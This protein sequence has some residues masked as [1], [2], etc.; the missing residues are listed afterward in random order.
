MNEPFSSVVNV[1]T[2]RDLSHSATDW[3]VLATSAT[4]TSCIVAEIW[5]SYFGKELEQPET[6]IVI[7]EVLQGDFYLS[8]ELCR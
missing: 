1:S 3:Y 5:P 7:V 8:R 6:K 2:W 4:A